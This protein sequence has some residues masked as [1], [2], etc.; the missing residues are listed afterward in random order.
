MYMT[1]INTMQPVIDAIQSEM[2]PR[3]V[4]M[5]IGYGITAC[6]AI[7]LAWW[8]VRTI[9][10]II[11]NAVTKGKLEIGT[12]DKEQNQRDYETWKKNNP[13]Y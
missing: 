7:V 2:N 9:I 4:A 12:I 1:I 3:N 5:L 10:S 6:I 8:G 11:M 13:D